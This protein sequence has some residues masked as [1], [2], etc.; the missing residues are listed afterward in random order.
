MKRELHPLLPR[1]EVTRRDALKLL[2]TGI[3]ALEAGCFERPGDKEIVPYVN[4]PPELRAGTPVRYSGALTLDGYGVG[5]LVDTHD[6]R[7][8]KLDGNPAHPASR[9]GS[10][11]WM[12]ARILDL[13]D[14]QRSRTAMLRGVPTSWPLLAKQ[15]RELPHGPVWL[16]MPPQSSPTVAALLAR[17]AARHDL[18]VIYH[19]PLA[20]TNVYRGHEL[21]YGRPLE[22]QVDLAAD[23]VVALDA[24]PFARGPMAAAWARAAASRRAPG[25]RMSRLWVAEPMPTP[26]GTLADERLAAPAGDIAAVATVVATTVGVALPDGLVRVA[27]ERLGPA[28]RWADRLAADLRGARAAIV[29]G[30]RQP[31]S[32]HAL[33]RMIDHALGAAPTMTV[34]AL[35]EPVPRHV[36]SELAGAPR[37]GTVIVLDC[38]PVYTAPHDAIGPAL[39]RANLSVHVGAY[40]DATAEACTA[41]VPLAHE[42]ET[43][44]DTRAYDGTL[45][46]GQPTLRPRFDV[47]SVI[48]VLAALAGLTLD[49]R[50]LVHDRMRGQA[51]LDAF[52]V[53]WTT[54]LRKGVVDGTRAPAEQVAPGWHGPRPLVDEL[55]DL[56]APPAAGTLELALAP[57]AVHDGRFAANAWLQELPH[58]ITKQTWGNAAI[59]SEAT[60]R[61]LGVGTGD[62]LA[63]A[64][65]GG[66]IELPALVIHGVASGSITVEIG[67]GQRGPA[68]AAGVGA[69]TYPLADASIA[70]ATAK[71]TGGAHAIVRTQH[72]FEAAGRDIAP[73]TTLHALT[74]KLTDHLRGD[75]PSML[76]ARHFTGP[77]WGM[78]IDTQLCSGCN[79]CVVACQAENNIPVVGPDDVAKGRA[80]HW[81]RIDRYVDG[82]QVVNEPMLCQH[83]ENAPCEYVCPVN[84]TDHSP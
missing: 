78:S 2:A 71:P 69:S 26:T 12:Q 45:S 73:M 21:V 40:R 43:W 72:Q 11:P 10:L 75:Q 60:A 39:G 8:T 82:D 36:L 76:P 74:P 35:L 81:I 59:V 61:A 83:C 5:I 25:A 66:T 42:L 31:P 65:H 48:D 13:Y 58:P 49:A 23:V 15:L 47:A 63:I 84:A 1:V 50:T 24:D 62:V 20:R 33:A 9:G 70:R 16:V 51:P 7:P 79:A 29:V 22:H 30:E 34:P 53:A 46:I 57:S 64:A 27:R 32:V 44:T 28:A 55:G 77:Q 54:A 41:H 3:A 80:M 18:R 19:A 17:I 4:E 6:G 56:L 14:P 52:D 68:I 38:D 37:T 67:Y